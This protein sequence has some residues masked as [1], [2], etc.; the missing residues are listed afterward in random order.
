[1]LIPYIQQQLSEGT[2]LS[3]ISRHILGLFQGQPGAKSWR[4]HISENAH[5]PGANAQ[6]ILDALELVGR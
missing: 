5:K 1:M 3:N 6:V 2:R 4:R